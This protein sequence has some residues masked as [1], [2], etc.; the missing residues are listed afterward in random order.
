[1]FRAKDAVVMSTPGYCMKRRTA[2]VNG[3]SPARR[4]KHGEQRVTPCRL[5]TLGDG[6]IP[7]GDECTKWGQETLE[8]DVGPTIRLRRACTRLI[9]VGL[10]AGMMLASHAHAGSART[11]PPS[12]IDPSLDLVKPGSDQARASDGDQN[13]RSRPMRICRNAPRSTRARALLVEVG[14]NFTLHGAD[15]EQGC[16]LTGLFGILALMLAGVGLY[17]VTAYAVERRTG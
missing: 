2:D 7:S 14:V 8:S 1:M 11:A 17:G 16:P 15:L 12:T 10:R 5:C 9:D 6:R 3:D 4:S 13:P